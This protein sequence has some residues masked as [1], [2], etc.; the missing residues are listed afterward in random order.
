MNAALNPSS[1]RLVKV[2]PFIP[3]PFSHTT[4]PTHTQIFITGIK[5]LYSFNYQF[6][7]WKMNMVIPVYFGRKILLGFCLKAADENE[8]AWN[9]SFSTTAQINNSNKQKHYFTRRF[10]FCTGPFRTLTA[11][12]HLW[13]DVMAVHKRSQWFDTLSRRTAKYCQIKTFHAKTEHCHWVLCRIFWENWIW[14]LWHLLNW[15]CG[16]KLLQCLFQVWM[17]SWNHILDDFFWLFLHLLNN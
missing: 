12:K 15:C 16:W 11:V 7:R 6:L 17:W 10:E 3:R 5:F 2:I 8:F 14:I 9:R 1:L 13:G 4:W